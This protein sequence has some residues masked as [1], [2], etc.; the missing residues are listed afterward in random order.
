MAAVAAGAIMPWMQHV[1]R[2]SLPIVGARLCPDSSLIKWII[3]ERQVERTDVADV[4]VHG[5]RLITTTWDYPAAA[6]ACG[7]WRR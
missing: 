3:L 1:R 4:C 5:P 6:A 2:R 7:Y